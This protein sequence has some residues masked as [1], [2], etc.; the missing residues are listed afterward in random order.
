MC[1]DWEI[2]MIQMGPKHVKYPSNIVYFYKLKKNLRNLIDQCLWI[3]NF[4]S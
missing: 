2:Y 3:R 1:V 4:P